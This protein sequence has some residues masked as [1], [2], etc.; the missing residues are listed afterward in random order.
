[1]QD[2]DY[3]FPV[4]DDEF[5]EDSAIYSDEEEVKQLD[6]P[7]LSKIKGPEQESG[8]DEFSIGDSLLTPAKQFIPN[9][10]SMPS[11]ESL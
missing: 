7:S 11:A 10:N 2:D 8:F 9:K 3:E 6:N 5:P 4:D 1:M